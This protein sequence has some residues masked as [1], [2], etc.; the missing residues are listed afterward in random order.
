MESFHDAG[1][2]LWDNGRM[3]VGRACRSAR[4]VLV[5]ETA[6]RRARS[7]APYPSQFM[8]RE[9]ATPR[10]KAECF[11]RLHFHHRILQQP[12]PADADLNPVAGAQGEFIR[13]HDTRAGQ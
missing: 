7:D 11:F 4:A 12:N 8:G 2:S 5:M 6:E 10:W 9:P 1:I 13:R 3:G